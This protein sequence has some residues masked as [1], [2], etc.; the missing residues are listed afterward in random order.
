MCLT[1]NADVSDSESGRVSPEVENTLAAPCS[2]LSQSKKQ[3]SQEGMLCSNTM[4]LE[5]HVTKDLVAAANNCLH[6]YVSVSS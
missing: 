4:L 6:P 2:C 5:A 1:A 3:A